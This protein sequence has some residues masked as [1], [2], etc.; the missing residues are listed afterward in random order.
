MGPRD[1]FAT[2]PPA[3]RPAERP[4]PESREAGEANGP[5]RIQAR[6]PDPPRPVPR[7]SGA[8]VIGAAL[9]LAVGLLFVLLSP[10]QA[11]LVLVLTAL[12]AALGAVVRAAFR[13][14]VDLEGAWRALRRR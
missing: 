2:P 8:V 11:V 3:E 7:G 4:G 9:G 13:D 1:P 12:G 6:M 14:G 5:V 10:G